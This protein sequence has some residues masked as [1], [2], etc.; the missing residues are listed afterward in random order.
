M[1]EP[2]GGTMTDHTEADRYDPFASA[3]GAAAAGPPPRIRL[4]SPVTGEEELAALAE[5]L[6][7]GVLTNGPFTR[8][9]EALMAERHQTEHAVAFCNGTIALEA[10]YRARGIGP[11]DEVIV[12]SMTFISTATS[13]LH[14]GATPVFADVLGDTLN[15]DPDDVARK[16]TPRTK[17]IV[18]VHYA[19]QAADMDRF[20]AIADDA[21]VFLVEDA[22]EAHG[23]TFGG[24]PV[25]SWGD[26]GMFSFTP[27]KNITT[28]E[29][30]MVTTDDGD[31]A[32]EL[33]LLRNHGMDAPYHHATLGYNWRISELQSALGC[34][35]LG[36]LD[37]I[38]ATKRANAETFEGLLGPIDGITAPTVAP[39]RD[40]PYMIYTTLVHGGRRQQVLDHLQAVGIE[41]R[42]YFPP[43]HRQ[44]VFVDRGIGAELPVTDEVAGQIL[45]LPFHAKLTH[46]DLRLIA[47]EVQQALS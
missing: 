44:P 5:V 20:R 37:G 39:D 38:L 32:R 16:L 43:A 18:P 45:S 11:G 40:H 2:T 13:V 14:V 36:R 31:L 24:R 27:T 47:K 28:G 29:G 21:G 34:V 42:I 8:R 33:R 22:A 25:G 35:Q 46:D 4:A 6:A 26:A 19:G 23:A 30:G 3:V 17:A 9:F 15:L 41:A 1:P 7:S 10:L 12:P